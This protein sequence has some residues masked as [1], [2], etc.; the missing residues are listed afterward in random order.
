MPPS[1]YT[2]IALGVPAP[3]DEV[4]FKQLRAMSDMELEQALFILA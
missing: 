2:Q 1:L 4:T 3:V